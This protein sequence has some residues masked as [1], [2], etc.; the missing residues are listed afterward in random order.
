MAERYFL[1]ILVSIT[2]AGSLWLSFVNP[3]ISYG[4]F[5][6]SLLGLLGLATVANAASVNK[7]RI[8]MPLFF[9]AAMAYE[10]YLSLNLRF[11]Y[12]LTSIFLLSL[13]G[14]VLGFGISPR[15]KLAKQAYNQAGPSAAV[16][17]SAGSPAKLQKKKASRKGRRRRGK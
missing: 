5:L 2:V 7:A 17:A 15:K 14:L 3:L 1:I 6:A 11:G 8:L 12:L 13:T 10:V 4:I 16:S 9:I